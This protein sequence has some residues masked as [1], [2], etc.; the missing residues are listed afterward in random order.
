MFASANIYKT[1]KLRL[2]MSEHVFVKLLFKNIITEMA[3]SSGF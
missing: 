3:F 1:T 2:S